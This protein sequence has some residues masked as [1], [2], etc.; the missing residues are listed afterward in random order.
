[1]WHES[2]VQVD[3]LQLKKSCILYVLEYNDESVNALRSI[4]R[5][6]RFSFCTCDRAKIVDGDVGDPQE[7]L[8]HRPDMIGDMTTKDLLW[9]VVSPCVL[10]LLAEAHITPSVIIYECLRCLCSPAKPNALSP[11]TV[12]LHEI[13][14]VDGLFL[15]YFL[16]YLNHS[17]MQ[18]RDLS[19][20]D[21]LLM[22]AVVNTRKIGHK[23]SCLNILGWVF[24]R[25]GLKSNALQCFIQSIR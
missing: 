4:P 14:Y 17:K 23:T 13:A 19:Q 1:M 12:Y 11:G 24:K 20:I 15:N 22:T 7:V 18:Q 3:S 21:I 25:E 16:L 5:G 9:N 6:V 2:N 8:I 10:F